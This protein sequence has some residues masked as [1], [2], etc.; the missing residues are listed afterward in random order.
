F[1]TNELRV[2]HRDELY[3]LLEEALSGDVAASW[4][5]RLMAAGVPSGAVNTIPAAIELAE[6]LGLEPVVEVGESKAVRNPI[7]LS[8][9]PTT[10]R[11]S[12]PRLGS[13]GN[14]VQ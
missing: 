3:E 10:H 9:T 4:V 12:S 14:D 6:S 1:I 13:A 7:T 11:T 2:A 5:E 8:R